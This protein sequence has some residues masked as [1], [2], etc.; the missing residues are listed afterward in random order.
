MYASYWSSD[1]HCG[2]VLSTP[3]V[4]NQLEPFVE[5][6]NHLNYFYSYLAQ[7]RHQLTDV[8][9]DRLGED[10]PQ[11]L[12]KF[13]K[14]IL[15]QVYSKI[16]HKIWS[17]DGLVDMVREE[18]AAALFCRGLPSVHQV[19]TGLQNA[20]NIIIRTLSQRLFAQKLTEGG[21]HIGLQ[22]ELIT[23]VF[24]NVLPECLRTGECVS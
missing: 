8:I 19:P 5:D 11:L 17:K 7:V 2:V 16:F 21:N 1:C 4:R 24:L 18:L 9:H 23:T 3:A 15:H 13:F 14:R 12:I 22:F 6:N 10:A 20:K